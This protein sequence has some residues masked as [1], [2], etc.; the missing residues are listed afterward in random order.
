M[1]YA[2]DSDVKVRLPKIVVKN[3][4]LHD[5][6]AKGKFITYMICIR[7]DHP[8]FHLHLSA[9]RRRFSEIR[10]LLNVLRANH[11]QIRFPV[12]PAK[13][14]FGE[15]FDSTFINSRLKEIEDFLNKLVATDTVLSDTAFHLFMQTDLTTQDID[16]YINGN[17]P[18]VTIERAWQG[19][20]H[21]HSPSYFVNTTAVPLEPQEIVMG[22]EDLR[23]SSQL[24]LSLE[25]SGSQSSL[26]TESLRPARL[27]VVNYN[28][29]RS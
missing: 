22:E 15:Q 6:W 28:D 1:M 3:P 9:V 27:D 4:V 17:L 23:Y 19:A 7:T 21:L 2:M 5:T 16:N 11:P 24:S 14:I 12:P 20:G 29:V 8:S 18:E 13:K 25:D 10:W 26:R